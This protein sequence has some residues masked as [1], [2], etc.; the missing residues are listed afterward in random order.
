MRHDP[1]P[2]TGCF[3]SCQRPA[4]CHYTGVRRAR[5]ASRAENARAS[6]AYDPVLPD[7][8]GQERADLI[9]FLQQCSRSKRRAPLTHTRQQP[10]P[11]GSHCLASQVQNV[12]MHLTLLLASHAC[13][14]PL[15]SRPTKWHHIR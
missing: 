5:L 11:L 2:W 7:R 4:I 8:G 13:G 9:V 15:A 3:G 14:M 10:P 1:P 12:D 6:V